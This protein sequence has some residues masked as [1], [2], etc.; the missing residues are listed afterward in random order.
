MG[1]GGNDALTGNSA[2]KTLTGGGGDDTPTGTG[3]DTLIGG[4]GD[5]TYNVKAGDTIVENSG[6]GTDS[7][8][9]TDSYPVCDCREPDAGRYV[10]RIRIR[11]PYVAG[12][13][14]G[15]ENGLEGGRPNAAR[16]Q[17]IVSVGGN[18]MF[19]MSSDPSVADFAGPYSPE[20]SSRQ[21]KPIRARSLTASRSVQLPGC[22][23][24]TGRFAS[25]NHLRQCGWY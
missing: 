21:A 6:Q 1:G 9:T 5:D 10:S 14:V 25:G 20:L 4:T 8:F 13:I 19:R 16:D 22:E 11:C 18:Q 23:R 7:V 24:D 12:P 3:N 17:E 15:G 2:V